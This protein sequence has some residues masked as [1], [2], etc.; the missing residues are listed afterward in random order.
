MCQKLPMLTFLAIFRPLTGNIA[1][2]AAENFAGNLVGNAAGNL[3]GNSTNV[4]NFWHIF[5][6]L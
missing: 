4:G 2:N 6:H 3:V 5:H 1:G